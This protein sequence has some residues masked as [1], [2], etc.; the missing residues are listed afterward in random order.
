MKNLAEA[1]LCKML[2][3]RGSCEELLVKVRVDNMNRVAFVE[4]LCR[5]INAHSNTQISSELG[6]YEY[7]KHHNTNTY[8]FIE[9]SIHVSGKNNFLVY[10]AKTPTVIFTD[11]A[12]SYR[13]HRKIMV[14]VIGYLAAAAFFSAAILGAVL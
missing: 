9:E 13:V 12:L 7:F 6:I 8:F 3:E 11:A 14:T 1:V 2:R 10:V 4:Q 5:K